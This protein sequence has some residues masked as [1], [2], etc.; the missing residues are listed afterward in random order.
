MCHLAD[1]NGTIE[2][3]LILVD[4]EDR[5]PRALLGDDG[6]HRLPRLRIARGKRIAEQLQHA[7]RKN[8]DLSVLIIEHSVAIG[9][10]SACAV[11]RILGTSGEIKL[12]S[13][14]WTELGVDDLSE[15]ERVWLDSLLS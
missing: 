10:G 7:I 8:L 11:A 9:I 3:R 2:Y 13:V 14:P 5:R 15:D 4:A 12:T 1:M 6:Y